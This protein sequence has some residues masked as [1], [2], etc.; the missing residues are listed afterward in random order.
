[1]RHQG[2]APDPTN[3]I[4]VVDE[5]NRAVRK[6]DHNLS[7]I[8]GDDADAV[9]LIARAVLEV[10]SAV[11]RFPMQP[12]GTESAAALSS[13]PLLVLPA[14][15]A[16][17]NHGTPFEPLIRIKRA[18]YASQ[19][20]LPAAVACRGHRRVVSGE[21]RQRSKVG[22]RVLRGGA[23]QAFVGKVAHER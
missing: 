2:L 3:K 19:S 12:A 9:V 22:C 7:A 8:A 15:T 5:R 1:M 17:L 20:P 4:V 6:A 14:N 23:R 13:G 10:N 16:I 11:G 21:R 18:T